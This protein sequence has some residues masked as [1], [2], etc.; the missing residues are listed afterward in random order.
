MDLSAHDRKSRAHTQISRDSLKYP[1]IE[2][3]MVDEPV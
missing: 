2:D 1:E 3:W